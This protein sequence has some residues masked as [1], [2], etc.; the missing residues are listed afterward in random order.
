MPAIYHPG[1]VTIIPKYDLGHP[2]NAANVLNWQTAAVGLTTAQLLAIQTAFDTAWKTG[3]IA[4]GSSANRYMG[5]WVID[6]SSATGGQVTNALYTPAAGVQGTTSIP[7]N[8][9]CLISLHTATRYRGGHGRIYIPG[10]SNT[11]VAT[12]GQ[13]VSTGTQTLL[14]TLWDSTV[15]AMAAISGAAGGPLNSVVWHKHLASAPNTTEIVLGRVIQPVIATQRRRL[16][17]VTRH[18]R[19]AA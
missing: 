13:T 11:Q 2:N 12:D 10:I 8:V 9:A 19:S 6:M 5:S 16:R 3:W 7:D 18:R 17:K 14:G 15:S 1:V 4:L